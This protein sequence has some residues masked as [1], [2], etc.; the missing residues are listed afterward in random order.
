M[1]GEIVE[2]TARAIV[3][4]IGRSLHR[5]RPAK[6]LY[7]GGGTPTYLEP[8]LFEKIF[9]MVQET[10]PLT[11]SCEIT[12]EANPGTVDAVRYRFLRELGVN[13]LSIG[14]QS[15]DDEELRALGRVHSSLEIF[16]A[17]ESARSVGFDNVNIDLMFG[18]PMQSL[19]KWERNLE[20]ALSLQPDHLSLYNLTI[21]PNTQFYKRW[22]RGILLFPDEDLQRDMFDLARVRTRQAG[23]RAYEISNYA[24]P[25]KECRHNLCY[26]Y[27]EEYVAYGPGAVERVGLVRRTHIKHPQRYCEAVERSEDLWSEV[28]FLDDEALR[29]E[30][31]MLRLRLDEGICLDEVRLEEAKLRKVLQGGLARLE[32]GRLTLTEEGFA[33]ANRVILSLV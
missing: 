27:G 21:E 4:E 2:R 28:D 29:L 12:V 16:R 13:R 26:W 17:Y 1:Q 7:F 10:H 11:S 24:R 18:L 30:T 33:M 23:Y 15:F 14:A 5:G 25:G 22:K 6:T 8:A 31:L 3:A 9:K 20:T 19:E 32:K